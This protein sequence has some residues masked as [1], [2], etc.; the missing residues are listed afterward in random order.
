MNREAMVK[1]PPKTATLGVETINC[2]TYGSCFQLAESRLEL[3]V[4]GYFLAFCDEIVSKL[5]VIKI[6]LWHLKKSYR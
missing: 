2:I 6:D 5:V 4:F 3:G 1:K